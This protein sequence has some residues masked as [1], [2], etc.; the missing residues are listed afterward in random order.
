MIKY[1]RTMSYEN[2]CKVV[3]FI[4]NNDKNDFAN[5]TT[6]GIQM[7]IDE[8]NYQ[9]ILNFIKTL[10]IFY[11][12]CDVAPYKVREQIVNVLKSKGIIK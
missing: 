3:D 9:T 8:K 12:I 6:G 10:N 5:I 7:D 1:V 4:N 2:A 11:E